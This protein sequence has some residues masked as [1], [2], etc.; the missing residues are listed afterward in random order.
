MAIA[1]PGNHGVIMVKTVYTNRTA[2]YSEKGAQKMFLF[3]FYSAETQEVPMVAE[4]PLPLDSYS[5][6]M[7][8]AVYFSSQYSATNTSQVQIP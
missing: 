4:S 8:E 6:T 3:L 7:Y 5:N 2:V 1:L